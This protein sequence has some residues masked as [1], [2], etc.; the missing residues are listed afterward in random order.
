MLLRKNKF[1]SISL[2]ENVLALKKAVH[3]WVGLNKSFQMIPKTMGWI[4]RICFKSWT[5]R[6]K[7]A[8]LSRFEGTKKG[9]LGNI[10]LKR[11]QSVKR[12]MR[13]KVYIPNVYRCV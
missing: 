12:W 8:F 9:F 7:R 3:I 6:V 10:Y 2:C 1:K 13:G 5:N 4:S 11:A